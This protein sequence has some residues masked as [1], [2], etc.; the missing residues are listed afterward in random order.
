MKA[1]KNARREAYAAKQ[2]KQGRRVVEWIIGVL[3]L[4]AVAYAVWASVMLS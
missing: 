4:L 2:E 1:K 3:V